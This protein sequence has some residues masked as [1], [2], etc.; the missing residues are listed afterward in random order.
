MDEVRRSLAPKIGFMP[1]MAQLI[2]EPVPKDTGAL[3]A[4]AEAQQTIVS[5]P[6]IESQAAW[7]KHFSVI[8][9]D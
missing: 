5:K 4:F 2:P 1:P 9:S 8:N 3:S 7:Q 6:F